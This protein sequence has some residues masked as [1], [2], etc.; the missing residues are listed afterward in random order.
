MNSI[1]SSV[2]LPGLGPVCPEC[3]SRGYVSAL[4]L[5]P[6]EVYSFGMT[7]P[8]S[9]LDWDVDTARALIAAR[10][11][12]AGR[13]DP[14]WL[15]TWLADRTSVTA[16]HLDHI[17]ADKLAEPAV[18]VEIMACPPEAEPQ[19]F[20]ILIDGTHRAARKLRD[21]QDCWAFLLT[22][23]EQRSICTYQLEGQ[24]VELP[25]F[26]GPGISDREAGILLTSV[27]EC[28]DVA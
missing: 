4:Q 7:E 10:P 12:T 22:E 13:L 16:E 15:K 23:D 28:D 14:S 6:K 27:A 1:I 3:F 18:L 25:S 26:P 21:R 11:R 24:V 9:Q 2:V 5:S 17:P 19:P 8:R 20:R